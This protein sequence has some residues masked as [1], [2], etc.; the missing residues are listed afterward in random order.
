M[1]RYIIRKVVAMIPKM[2]I[3]SLIVFFGLQLLPG[4]PITRTFPP[5]QLA[6]LTETQIETLREAA[7]LNDPLMVQ[8]FSWLTRILKGDLGYSLTS[9]SN[10]GQMLAARLP[11]TM[12]LAGWSLLISSILGIAFGFLAAVRQNTL[13]DYS[14]TGFSVLG[15]SVPEFFF[16]IMFIMLFSMKLGWLPSGGRTSAEDT[17]A[18]FSH[19]KYLI[20]PVLCLGISFLASLTRYTR[21]CML[22]VMNK[23]YIKTARSKGISESSV[24]FKHGL[25]N[26]LSPVMTLLIF[27]LPSLVCGVVVIETVFNYPAVGTMLIQAI[28]AADMPTVMVT[29]MIIAIVTLI[30]STLVDIV[31]AA[32]DPRIRLE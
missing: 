12:E 15:I 21:G 1:T 18:F 22:D 17:G 20:M 30:A 13:T 9:K 8:Y 5:E 2:L 16:G 6:K 29:A 23:D 27:Q 25:R 28:N 3:I 32:L 11:Y 24:Y 7:G 19:A 10:I 26:A 14:L 31:A 4:D